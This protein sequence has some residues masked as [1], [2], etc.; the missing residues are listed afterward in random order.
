MRTEWMMD[1][2]ENNGDDPI[3]LLGNWIGLDFGRNRDTHNGKHGQG[4]GNQVLYFNPSLFFKYFPWSSLASLNLAF[5]PSSLKS[6]AL[7]K[8][9]IIEWNG[10]ELEF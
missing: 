3:G 7:D 1:E 10:L 6:S 5:A 8:I 2:N 4:R 9:L